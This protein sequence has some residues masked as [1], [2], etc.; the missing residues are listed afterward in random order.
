ML[1]IRNMGHF[2]MHSVVR[3]VSLCPVDPSVAKFMKKI[4]YDTVKYREDNNI[5]RPDFMNIMIE[6]KNSQIAANKTAQANS[7]EPESK[8]LSFFH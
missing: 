3:A 4:V 8:N 7:R 2:F 1:F 5:T 6:M